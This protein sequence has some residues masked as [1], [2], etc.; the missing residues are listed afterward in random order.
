MVVARKILIIDDNP[1]AA[2]CL[3]I[4]LEMNGHNVATAASGEAGLLIAERF[5][6]EF[7]FLDIG[8]PGIDGYDTCRS[9][10]ASPRGD[11]IGIFAITGWGNEDD[12]RKAKA[13]GFDNHMTKPI[14]LVKLEELLAEQRV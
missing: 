8:L 2:D 3:C 4:V 6:P 13:A 5:E 11:A 10:R 14:D 7:V 1:D 9:L 12:K